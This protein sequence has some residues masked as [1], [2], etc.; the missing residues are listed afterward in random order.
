MY[1]WKDWII[2]FREDI[3]SY[4]KMRYEDYCKD[5]KEEYGIYSE[6][7]FIR[8]RHEI[9]QN[10]LI[11]LGIKLRKKLRFFRDKSRKELFRQHIS[12]LNLSED[13]FKDKYNDFCKELEE[14]NDVLSLHKQKSSYILNIEKK[15][16]KER[17]L[18]F[19]EAMKDTRFIKIIDLRKENY[20]KRKAKEEKRKI[21]RKAKKERVERRQGLSNIK[22]ISFYEELYK[23]EDI[24]YDNEIIKQELIYDIYFQKNGKPIGVWKTYRTKNYD[25]K[26]KWI[27][28]GSFSDEEV[29]KYILSDNPEENQTCLNNCKEIRNIIIDLDESQREYLHDVDILQKYL[30]KKYLITRQIAWFVYCLKFRLIEVLSI[31]PNNPKLTLR[32]HPS[33]EYDFNIYNNDFDIIKVKEDVSE[34]IRISE[35]MILTPIEYLKKV[36]LN[37]HDNITIK[38]YSLFIKKSEK[39]AHRILNGFVKEKK[40]KSGKIG[41][42]HKIIYFV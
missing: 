1:D 2:N 7:D 11:K 24:E 37:Q 42:S 5:R 12:E 33:R 15:K 18:K 21:K 3:A 22:P 17:L 39:V 36:Y 28:D 16:E 32:N 4:L 27:G 38:Q 34:F 35:G 29:D 19:K 23:S 40:L 20:E 25:E 14:T 13:Y 26:K 30:T 10:E 41:S 9:K 8:E 6:H 31:D